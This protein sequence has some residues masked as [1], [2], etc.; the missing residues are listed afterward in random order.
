M[1][2][3]PSSESWVKA[4]VDDLSSPAPRLLIDHAHCEKKAAAMALRHIERHATWPRLAQRMSRLAREELVHFE[5]VLAELRARRL[6]FRA[7]PASG[8]GA[9]LLAAVRTPTANRPG[10]VGSWLGERTVDEMLVC[11]IIEARSH[12]RFVRLSGALEPVDAT[13]A[14][15]YAELR[16]AEARHGEIY[17]SLAEEVAGS[18]IDARLAELLRHEADV[19]A[20]PGQP[21]RIHSG[22]VQNDAE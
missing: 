15:M 6:R 14:Q 13:L 7:Q 9:A 10:G 18:S 5:R 11:A 17:L 22:G 21:L 12:E 19:I 1:N 16:D 3:A 4:A 2:L 8:Y 20:R